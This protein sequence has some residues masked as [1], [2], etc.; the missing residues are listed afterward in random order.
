MHP[1]ARILT[2]A[3]IGLSTASALAAAPYPNTGNFGVPFSKDESWHQQCMRV[4]KL[5]APP[6][7]AVSGPCDAGDLYYTKR[8]QAVT[9]PAEWNKVRACA[10]TRA[11]NS[12]LMMLYA[13]GF[14]VQRD[15]GM[16]MHY[17]CS[18][19]FIAK[20]EMEH[21]IEHLAGAPRSGVP[22]DQCDDITSGH[23]GTI[24]EAIR[25]RHDDRVRVARLDRIASAMSPASRSAFAK[26]RAAAERYAT[27]ATGEVDMQGTAAPA[28]SM[29]HVERL[30]EEFMQ[31]ALDTASGKLLPA[32]PA[33]F[34]QRDAELNAL[35]KAVMS[36]PTA[37]ENWP[38]NIG[39]ST[40]S[41]A[42]VRKT[43]RLWLAYRD[44]F[45]AYVGTLPSGPEPVAVKALL[46]SQRIAALAKIARYRSPA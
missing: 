36:A 39:D 29:E 35:Y 41:H 28:L 9:S 44:A 26:L 4:A 30:Q 7:P 6:M 8:N 15:A 33:E 20:S 23:M 42:A 46:T 43:E 45:V 13:N 14:G 27:E 5:K 25:A 16:A 11:D 38:D 1:F 37:R 24:C 22:F 34:A 3:A 12:V 10:I 32:S 31:A 40:I 2:L 21:R 18:L 19:D 17:A